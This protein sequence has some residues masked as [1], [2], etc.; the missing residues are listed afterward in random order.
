MI[1][2]FGI[3]EIIFSIFPLLVMWVS[4]WTYI[5]RCSSWGERIL[6]IGLSF[7]GQPLGF[8]EDR[9]EFIEQVMEPFSRLIDSRGTWADSSP[10]LPI[11]FWVLAL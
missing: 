2:S 7:W 3:S 11:Q 6:V 4:V 8:S 1:P 9:F 5:H 10:R